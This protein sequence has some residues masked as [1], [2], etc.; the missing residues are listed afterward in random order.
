[1]VLCLAWHKGLHSGCQSHARAAARSRPY[2]WPMR[3]LLLSIRAGRGHSAETEALTQQYLQHIA[4]TFSAQ[5]K[6][7]RTEGALLEEWFA[8][9]KAGAM[10]VWLADG[11]GIPL[12]SEK[13]AARLQK[14]AESGKRTL[15][16]AVGPADGWSALARQQAADAGALMLSIG[17]MTLPHELARLVLAEQLYR[18]TT[19]L[20]GHPYHVG[21]E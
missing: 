15:L 8:H 11:N 13:L 18:A 5:T 17:P 19:I 21:H 20:A 1:M 10:A 7:F 6:V 4:G 14:E 9:R 3:I 16:V 2:T 12:S